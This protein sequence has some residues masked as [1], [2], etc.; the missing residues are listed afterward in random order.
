MV[1][2]AARLGSSLHA[3]ISVS[4]AG[5]RVGGG[6]GHASCLQQVGGSFVISV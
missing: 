4:R 5:G 3:A 1:D 2:S 6:R